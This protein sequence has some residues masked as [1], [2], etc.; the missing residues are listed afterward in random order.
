M[1]IRPVKRLIKAKP[2]LEGRVCAAGGRS[3]SARRIAMTTQ[4]ELQ[5]GFA[6]H[7]DGTFVRLD[8]PH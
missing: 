5:H 6:Q 3:A 7:Q 1:T 2:T 8:A 4:A